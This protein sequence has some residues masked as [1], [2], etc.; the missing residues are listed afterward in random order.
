M[1][2]RWLFLVAVGGT[3]ALAWRSGT[4]DPDEQLA[5][6]LDALCAIARD[7]VDQP[8]AGVRALGGYLGEHTGDLLGELGATIQLIERI[9]DD[10]RH[11]ERARLA[12]ER[13]HAPLLACAADWARFSDAV[14]ASPEAS[15]LIGRAT[16][17][18]GRTL[19]IIFSGTPAVPHALRTLPALL[20]AR[21][22]YD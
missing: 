20:A 19:E 8:T 5:A 9:P 4:T 22:A 12:R 2:K 7:H 10:G 11:D 13:I 17:R 14:E 3:A 1:T 16:D 6:R 21:V 18:L 15:E